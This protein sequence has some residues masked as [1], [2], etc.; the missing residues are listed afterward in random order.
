MQPEAPVATPAAIEKPTY[1]TSKQHLF[2]SSCAAWLVILLLAGG[3]VM[4]SEQAVA[5]GA[6]AVPTM[7]GL[8]L[9]MLGIHRG[10]GSLDMNTLAKHPRDDPLPGERE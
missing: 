10:F 6:I 8:I 2:Y 5:F 7:A 3:A 4:G 1:G 9:G